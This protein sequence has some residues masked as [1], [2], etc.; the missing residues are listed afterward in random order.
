MDSLKL[1]RFPQAYDVV[2]HG[3]EEGLHPGWQV[4][5]WRDGEVLVDDAFGEARPGRSMTSQSINMW[6]SATKPLVAV[7]FAQLWERGAVNLEEPVAQIIP[8]FA[9]G[10]KEGITFHHLLTHTGC[11]PQFSERDETWE[12]TIARV[13]ALPLETEC[14]P[15]ETAA[16]H[17]SSSWYV[18][19]EAIRRLDGRPVEE[20]LHDE[21]FVPLGMES[22]S[23]GLPEERMSTV[24]DRLAWTYRRSPADGELSPITE[25]NTGWGLHSPRPASNGRGTAR[26]LTRFYRMMMQG[27]LWRGHRLLEARTVKRLTA[28]TRIGLYDETFRHTIDWGL[29]FM[30]ESSRYGVE[31]VP[32]GFGSH[33]S[34]SAYGHGGR[35]SSVGFADPTH[36]L[37]VAAVFNGMPGEARHQRR[38]RT[39]L[40]NLYADLGIGRAR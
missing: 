17:M 20:Y 37:V 39:F 9:Q 18:L 14:R 11:F 21:I 6:M 32:Y 29:G 31:S 1:R 27:G 33:A 30:V 36:R 2:Q 4:C 3:I 13:C 15:G 34:P 16:Y 7:A 8:E 26:D 19:G 22:W 24:A 35:E 23:L 40:T 12:E 5:V 28:P 38:M 25:L 10:G